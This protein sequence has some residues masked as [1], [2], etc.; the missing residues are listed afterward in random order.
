MRL[1][2]AVV[3]NS[4]AGMDSKSSVQQ[5]FGPVAT[6]YATSAVHAG[7]P[8]LAAMIQAVT[9]RGDERVLDAGCGAGH[10]ALAFAPHVAEVVAV[11]LTLAMLTQVRRLAKERGLANVVAVRGDV[12]KLQFPDNSFDLVTTRYSAHHWPRP[13]AA[14]QEFARVLK[15]GGTLLLVD[16]VAPPAPLP[17]TFLNTIELLRDPSHVRDHSAAQWQAMM[18]AA[19]FAAEF[20]GQWPLFLEFES[21]VARM[22]T[23]FLS[24]TQI[25]TLIEG[26]P[27]EVR[28]A[29]LLTEGSY[30]FTVP[31]ALL[32]AQRG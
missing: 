31:V 6:H 23:P 16:V 18:E 9:L 17:D 20:I 25:R 3:K 27:Q 10:T 28:E 4:E 29:L 5:Q 19:G 12:E 11:D 26:A 13:A 22:N 14:M 30:S 32:R 15:P 24:I 7:G 2:T 8:D 1:H 21:W